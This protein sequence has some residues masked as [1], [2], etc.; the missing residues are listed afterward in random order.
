MRA[1]REDLGDSGRTGTRS[2]GARGA[3]VSSHSE[4][5][6]PSGFPE[7]ACKP[8]LIPGGMAPNMSITPQVGGESLL[9]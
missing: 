1:E 2:Q 6:C 7:K 9:D 8:K 3:V 4:T 5:Q